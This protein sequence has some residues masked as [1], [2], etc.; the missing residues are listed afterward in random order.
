MK[1][2]RYGSKVKFTAALLCVCFL[3]VLLLSSVYEIREINHECTGHNCPICAHIQQIE[4]N[5]NHLTTAV[6]SFSLF[7]TL[8]TNSLATLFLSSSFRIELSP[9]QLKVKMNN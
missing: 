4:N 5:R 9:I 8:F 2:K 7:A 1:T 6:V 3:M